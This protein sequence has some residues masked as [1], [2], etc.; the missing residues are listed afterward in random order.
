MRAFGP[1]SLFGLNFAMH[2]SL[3]AFALWRML[4]RRKAVSA[5]RVETTTAKTATGMP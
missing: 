5:P 1:A 2:L 4:A 3:A